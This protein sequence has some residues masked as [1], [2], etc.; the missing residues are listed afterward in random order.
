MQA[1]IVLEN[2]GVRLPHRTLFQGVNWTLYEGSRVTLAGRN[3]SGKSTLLRIM[4]NQIEATEGSCNTVGR[5]RLKVGYLDQSLLDATVIATTASP[6]NQDSAV[7]FLDSTLSSED[8]HDSG[9]VD[10]KWRVRKMLGGLGF[11]DDS[12]DSPISH[13]SGGWLLRMFIARTLLSAPDVLL[14]D[15]PTNHLDMSSIQWLEEFLKNEFEGSLVLVTHD[16]S[17]Q[18]RTT[19]SLAVLHGGK[20]YFRKHQSDYLAFRDSLGD[21]KRIVEK[22]IDSIDKKVNEYQTFVNKF[23]AKARSASRAQSKLKDIAILNE[24]RAELKTRLEQIEGFKYDLHFRFRAGSQGGKFPVVAENLDFRYKPDAPLILKN[25]SFDVAR[26]QKIAIIG[27][28]GAGKTTLLNLLAQ[29]LQPTQGEVTLGHQVDLGYFGQ[30][31]L[32]ELDLEET[33]FDNIRL[34]AKGIS[35]EQMR[36]WLGAFGFQGDH[37][38]QKK[39]KV[40]SGGEKARLALLRI[41]T[42]PI[43]V[44]FLDEPTNHLDIETRELLKGAIKSFEGTAIFVSH[45]RDFVQEIAERILFISSDHQLFDHIG[46]LESFFR[47]FPQ[48]LRHNETQKSVKKT[49]KATTADNTL[50]YEER[51]K[52]KNRLRSLEKKVANTESEM[53]RQG[54]EKGLLLEKI[55]SP[56]FYNENTEEEQKE[57]L[58]KQ[59]IINKRIHQLMVEWEKWSLELE[60]LQKK[61][62]NFEK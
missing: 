60:E 52:L 26:G 36:G 37:E 47:K 54:E 25:V 3:G 13:L 39:A 34:K 2:V 40:I 41:L 46:N 51:K 45:D 16:I 42:T 61:H 10:S 49:P 28:N 29:R 35:A 33:V 5:R 23:R 59:D 4:A 6:Q 58:E 31:Q 14:L 22:T 24:E 20:F 19:D 57:I 53:E 62:P 32:E 50:S 8:D 43:N 56:K 44:C 27:D 48:F 7:E 38:I 30:H 9:M 15:E 21:E 18:R 1:Q 12:M 17:L 11:T 55:S